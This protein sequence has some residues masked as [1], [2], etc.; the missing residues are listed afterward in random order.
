[1]EMH[2]PKRLIFSLIIF[3]ILIGTGIYGAI[4]IRS[5]LV[6]RQQTA[7]E[8]IKKIE[9]Q[10]IT[11][12]EGWTVN[13][14]ALYL[15]KKGVVT[16]EEFL[17]VQSKFDTTDFPKLASIPKENGLEGFLFP[18]TYRILKDTTSEEI[19]K[20]L[21]AN[22]EK[23]FATATAGSTLQDTRYIIPGYENLTLKG[24]KGLTQYQ[25]LTLASIVEREASS[26]GDPER[27]LEEQKTIAGI[28]YNRLL[29]GKALESD[30]T[31][32][33]I[34]GAG[35]PSPTHDD[36]DQDSPYNSY[37]YPGLPPGPIGNPGLSTL[38]AVLRP[39]KSD[40]YYFLHK[41]PSGEVV[42]SKTFDEHVQNKFKYLK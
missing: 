12:L 20:K 9:E 2:I 8:P 21:L 5:A 28:F 17:K 3:I 11:L 36:L 15:D 10:N 27:I 19:I 24:K 32:N 35:R 31:I 7:R 26:S 1:M 39:S 40:Y 25:I 22:F 16:A 34:T 6:A 37:K 23:K 42:Y 30:A 38:T 14:I 33:Y 13:D 4:K 18:D 29:Q 41:Q